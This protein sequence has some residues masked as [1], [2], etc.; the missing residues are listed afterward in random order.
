MGEIILSG[1]RRVGQLMTTVLRQFNPMDTNNDN[2]RLNDLESLAK[3]VGAFSFSFHQ[4]IQNKH[5]NTYT[6]NSKL[7]Y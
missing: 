7:S 6:D 5:R 2:N 3:V 4:Y 1:R